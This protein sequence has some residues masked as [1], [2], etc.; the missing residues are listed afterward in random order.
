MIWNEYIECM[1]R[2][3]LVKLQNERLSAVIIRTDAIQQAISILEKHKMELIRTSDIYEVY[4]Y[5]LKLIEF[6]TARF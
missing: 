1:D 6:N 5:Y 2:E 3:Q 4:K